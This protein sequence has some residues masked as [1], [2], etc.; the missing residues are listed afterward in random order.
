MSGAYSPHSVGTA[1]LDADAVCEVCGTVN[2]EGTFICRTCGNN[3]RD[4]KSRRLSSELQMLEPEG[5]RGIQV[6]RG[7][8]VI[9]GMLLIGWVAINVNQITDAIAGTGGA[10]DPISGLFNSSVSATYDSMLLEAQ[11]LNPTFEQMEAIR[12]T[13]IVGPSIDGNYVVVR[14]DYYAGLE[15]VGSAVVRTDETGTHFVAALGPDLHVRGTARNQGQ[16]ALRADWSEA[17]AQDATGRIYAVTGVAVPQLDGSVECF[18][19]SAADE[20]ANFEVSAY[21]LP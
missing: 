18:G 3:L 10:N 20:T 16:N 15:I 11:A 4:Q 7:A 2:P 6:F 12:A 9:F 14:N 13:P 17:A 8:L 19:Q 1:A 21:R 5:V